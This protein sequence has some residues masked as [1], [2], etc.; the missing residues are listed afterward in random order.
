M[1]Q[2]NT[3]RTG[4]AAEKARRG[5]GPHLPLLCKQTEAGQTDG[6]RASAGRGSDLHRSSWPGST[7]EQ[8]LGL[9]T[10]RKWVFL[11]ARGEKG[12]EDM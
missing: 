7:G 11:V 5:G 10:P 4:N 6:T 12:G 1:E 3:L 9:D 2:E 8:L